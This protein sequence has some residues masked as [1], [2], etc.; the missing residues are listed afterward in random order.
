MVAHTTL[1]EISCRGSFCLR[2]K[3][4]TSQT[5]AIIMNT[6]F[7]W[8]SEIGFYENNCPITYLFEHLVKLEWLK[9]ASLAHSTLS[10]L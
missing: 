10:V 5:C 6:I 8:R 1:L 7:G 2:Q 9:L 4:Q 3:S